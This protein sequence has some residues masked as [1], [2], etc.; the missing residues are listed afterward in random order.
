MI[1]SR[2]KEAVM[3][4]GRGR[5]AKSEKIV[6]KCQQ[7][8]KEWQAYEWDK[9]EH[10]CSRDCFYASRV[11]RGRKLADNEREQRKCLR[12]GKTFVVGGAGNRPRIAKYCSRICARHGYWAQVL[13]E[14]GSLHHTARQ[15]SE[16]ERAWFPGLF[17]G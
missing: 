2:N 16:L 9:K 12:C 8:G 15:M 14:Q 13:G 6:R 17:D 5:P 4:R 1:A 11:G 3:Q 10:Y 7:C